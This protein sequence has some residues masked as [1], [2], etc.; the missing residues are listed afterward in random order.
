[1]HTGDWCSI[2]DTVQYFSSVAALAC[3]TGAAV[4][5]CSTHAA[6]LACTSLTADLTPS[7]G[8]FDTWFF[9]RICSSWCVLSLWRTYSIYYFDFIDWVFWAFFFDWYSW[10]ICFV[11]S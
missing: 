3:A 10:G 7:C 9:T 6:V 5:A 2:W 8:G 11:V 1:M 4:L